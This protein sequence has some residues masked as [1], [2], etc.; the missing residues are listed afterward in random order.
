MKNLRKYKHLI[1][2]GSLLSLILINATSCKKNLL[3][4][5]I[6]SL[7]PDVAVFDTPERILAQVNGLYVAAKSGSFYGGRYIIYNEIRGEDFI[8]NKP[9]VVTGQQTWSQSVNP[10]TSE[11]SSLWTAGYLTINRVNTFLAG[12]DANKS[13][14]SA[15]LYA[16][17]SAEAK[18]LRALT[19]FALVQTYAQPYAK[20][21]GTSPGL[22]LRLMPELNSENSLLARSTVAKVYEQILADLNAAETGLPL[23]YGTGSTTAVA[24]LNTT[25]AS[26]NTAI[27]LKTRVYMVMN[28]YNAVITEAEKIV[29]ASA[30]YSAT[31]GV[32]NKME[33]NVAT[34]FTGNY[35]GPEAVFSLPFTPLETPGGQ[36]QLAYYFGGNP[37]N[38]EFYLNPVGIIADPAFAT[39][40]KDAR[41]GFVQ[42]VAGQKWMSK[43][44]VASTF[45]DNVPVIRYPEVLLNYAEALVRTGGVANMPKAISLLQAVRLR[46]DADYIFPAASI[47]TPDALIETILKEKRIEFFGEGFRVPDLQRLLQ[48]LPAK[49]STSNNAPTVA[50][51]EGRYIW[52]LP[53]S[54]TSINTAAEQNPQ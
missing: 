51:T 4:P 46:S 29:S 7:I 40:S 28:N 9:N 47:A 3:N 36:N 18:F 44:K 27:A 11:V 25:R 1:V 21:N 34:V 41:K 10:G 37:G 43:F 33:T 19:Y 17:Y 14:V 48:P 16:N 6:I 38:Q 31:T 30:P 53:S 45:S 8:M 26:R 15:T 12:L 42:T 5:D 22:P 23:N 35:V 50:P 54:E 32:A 39:A 13:K 2:R 49:A 20:N 24:S 52:P